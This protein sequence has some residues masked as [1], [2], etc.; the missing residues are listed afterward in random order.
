MRKATL[1]LLLAGRLP[2]TTPQP[3]REAFP[4]IPCVCE[5]MLD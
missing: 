2:K 1:T 5:L 4:I 3:E